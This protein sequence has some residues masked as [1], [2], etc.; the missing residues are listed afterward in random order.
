MSTLV[1]S[2]LRKFLQSGGE[3]TG[4]K[5]RTGSRPVTQKIAER[6]VADYINGEQASGRRP[7]LSGL[8]AAAK[9][10]EMHGGREYLRA[11]FHQ[12]SGVDVRRGRPPKTATK[13]AEK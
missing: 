1:P 7:T 4:A 5:A 6:F 2:S 3:P 8:E 10:A 9:K 12:S 11:A 13:I